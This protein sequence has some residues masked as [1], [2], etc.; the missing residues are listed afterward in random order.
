MED[1]HLLKKLVRDQNSGSNF[2]TDTH[3]KVK[4]LKRGGSQNRIQ[5]GKFGFQ[6]KTYQNQSFV[7]KSTQF[8]WQEI[9][10]ASIS[11]FVSGAGV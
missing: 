4:E 8:G 6:Y 11:P 2:Q 10:F 1:K 3:L 5:N 7:I 9:G